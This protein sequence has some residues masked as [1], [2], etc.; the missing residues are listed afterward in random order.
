MAGSVFL[1][2]F[3]CGSNPASPKAAAE[4]SPSAVVAT[5]PPTPSP[6]VPSVARS[7]GVHAGAPASI[8]V[9]VATV[10][11]SPNWV[12][13]VDKPATENPVRI[14]EWLSAMS[15]SQRRDLGPKRVNT[16]V[17]FG[18]LVQVVSVSGDWAEVVVPSQASPR[19]PRGYPGFVPVRQLSLSVPPEGP[20]IATVVAHTTRL[21]AASG[22]GE[23][24]VSYAT[25]LPALKA[26]GTSVE[27]WSPNGSSLLVPLKDVVIS[28]SDVPALPRT[29]D[30]IVSDAHRFLGLPYLW[31][32]SSAFGFDCSGI[33]YSVFRTHGVLLPRDS[34][35]QVEVGREVAQSDLRAGDLIFFA[36][37][38]GKVHHVGIY[39]GNGSMLHAPKTGETVQVSD[40]NSSWFPGEFHK[41]RRYIE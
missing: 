16:S 8:A 24:E 17:L 31:D 12:R 3:G 19:D 6:I 34:F 5:V 4:S 29:A 35:G 14:R 18:E 22:D 10:W 20:E 39:V 9:S 41:A 26:D 21:R 15:L 7:S 30:A 23:L 40:L 1:V 2:L 38:G 13:S 37:P 27:V 11:G 32:G 33:T 28:K 25:R 36:P